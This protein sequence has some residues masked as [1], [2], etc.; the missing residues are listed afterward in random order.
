VRAGSV[1]WRYSW[2][3]A[4][5]LPLLTGVARE[6]H[7]PILRTVAALTDSGALGLKSSNA[8]HEHVKNGTGDGRVA[9]EH[10][11]GSTS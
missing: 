7:G 4:Y 9:I 1:T 2:P 5:L 10:A 8:A 11:H 3:R 6:R